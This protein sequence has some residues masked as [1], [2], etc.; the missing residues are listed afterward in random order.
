RPLPGMRACVLDESRRLVP[1]GTE[2][3][4]YLS[5][6]QLAR[7]YVDAE[8]LTARQFV[9]C[10][11]VA[12]GRFYKTG[13][14]VRHGADGRLVHLGRTD[15]QVKVR[16]YRVELDEIENVLAGHA[17]VAAAAVL[18][19]GEGAAPRQLIAYIVPAP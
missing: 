3:E 16:G 7:G 5:G 14:R 11:E 6:P 12:E 4:L 18:Y 8:D 10:P 19:E 15:R 13:D 1:P 17:A 9:A 2:G